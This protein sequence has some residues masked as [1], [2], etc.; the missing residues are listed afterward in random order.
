MMVM[1]AHAREISTSKMGFLLFQR[2]WALK[3]THLHPLGTVFSVLGEVEMTYGLQGAE[4]GCSLDASTGMAPSHRK[5]SC[6]SSAQPV[7]A[8]HRPKT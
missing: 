6:Q 5:L 8:R 1:K 3:A 2:T 7:T 4:S